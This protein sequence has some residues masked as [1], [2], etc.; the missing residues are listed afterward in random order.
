MNRRAQGI[1]VNVI[2][3]AA[4][5]LVV[6]VILI[7]LVLNTGS[8]INNSVSS[9]EAQEGSMCKDQFESC[10]AGYVNLPTRSCTT[11]TYTADNPGKCC[12]PI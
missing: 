12:I 7:A 11:N 4:I 1:S 3:I 9:C 6:M 10:D 2:I 5:A 8:G